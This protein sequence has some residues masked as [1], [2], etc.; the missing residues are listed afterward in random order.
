MISK[1]NRATSEMV[2]KI[3]KDG[4]IITS[5]AFFSCRF[6]KAEGSHHVA[7]VAPKTIFKTAIERNSIRRK[8]YNS[9]PRDLG[10]T[11]QGVYVFVLKNS[12]QKI[13]TEERIKSLSFLN[14]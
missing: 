12:G 13:N 5:N 9:L 14:K 4:K 1:K 10:K 2:S 8:W 6:M 11:K 3:F 7:F